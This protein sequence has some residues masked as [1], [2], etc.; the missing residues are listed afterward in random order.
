MNITTVKGTLN[1]LKKIRVLIQ[2]LNCR[3]SVK[4][5]KGEV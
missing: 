1:S 4:E 5:I 2:R 3:S